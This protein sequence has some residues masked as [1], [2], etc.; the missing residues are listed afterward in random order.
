MPPK[1]SIDP[2]VSSQNKDRF[3]NLKTSEGDI[4][5]KLLGGE[6]FNHSS[7]TRALYDGEA[8]EVDKKKSKAQYDAILMELLDNDMVKKQGYDY[9][10]KD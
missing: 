7:F 6:G 2:A 8:K 5:K 1:P 4:A 3:K 10:Y 9:F